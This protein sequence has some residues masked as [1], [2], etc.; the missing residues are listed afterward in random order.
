MFC[1]IFNFQTRSSNYTL[2]FRC[3]VNPKQILSTYRIKNW[4]ALKIFQ[5]S[6]LR[7]YYNLCIVKNSI[8]YTQQRV[9]LIE[10]MTQWRGIFPA[11]KY[12]VVILLLLKRLSI[13]LESKRLL[14]FSSSEWLWFL[15]AEWSILVDLNDR[16]M[17][18]ID[19]R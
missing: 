7:N 3:D 4:Y 14:S 13:K 2:A 8:Q 12:V 11:C 18:D 19:D 5:R 9:I 17:V 1:T 10:V 6:F 15:V 16:W